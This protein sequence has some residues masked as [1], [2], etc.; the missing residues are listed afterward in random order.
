MLLSAAYDG[1]DAHDVPGFRRTADACFR[2]F[3][4]SCEGIRSQGR[5]LYSGCN[6]NT[7][8]VRLYCFSGECSLMLVKERHL[9]ALLL[10]PKL[11]P[12]R[13]SHLRRN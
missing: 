8:S 3:G 2:T 5:Y 9:S 10:A 12:K 13:F 7:N 1:L 6:Q 11:A 4:V